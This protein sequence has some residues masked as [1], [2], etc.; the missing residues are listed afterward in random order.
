[1]KIEAL[2]KLEVI[3]TSFSCGELEYVLAEKSE[4]N[5]KLLLDA[6]FTKEEIEEATGNDELD[7]DL[8]TLALNFTEATNWSKAKG[9]FYWSEEAAHE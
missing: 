4:G 8:S 5:V 1:M 9:F 2:N 7:I 3:E 6:G